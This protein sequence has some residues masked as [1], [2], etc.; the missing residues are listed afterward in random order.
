MPAET[1]IRPATPD[2]IPLILQLIRDLAEYERDP[3]AAVATPDLIRQHLFGDSLAGQP[4]VNGAP[5]RGPV[6]E[7]LIGE[8]GGAAQGFALFLHNFSTWRGRPGL[9]LEDLFV[10][11]TAR[12]H[13][14]GKALLI[15][16]AKIAKARNCARMEWA[17][18]DWNTPAIEFYKSLGAKAMNEWT[19]Y[20]LEESGIAKLAQSEPSG[21]SRR[22]TH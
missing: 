5:R 4:H 17:V 13:G 9:Y 6:G 21:A 22:S 16:L 12:G 18:L 8:I 11:P 1:R 2:D 10:R 14:L 3:A 20:R 7:C 15:E 19:V